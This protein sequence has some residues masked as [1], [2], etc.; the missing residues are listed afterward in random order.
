MLV[1]YSEFAHYSINVL[2]LVYPLAEDE[3]RV[4]PLERRASYAY[5]TDIVEG[6]SRLFGE[7]FDAV[8]TPRPR[9]FRQQFDKAEQLRLIPASLGRDLHDLKSLRNEV[10]HENPR[11]DAGLELYPQ[12]GKLCAVGFALF[13]VFVALYKSR[14]KQSPEAAAV[15]TVDRDYL[16]AALENPQRYQT[17]NPH[18]P[19]WERADIPK[20]MQ[21][22]QSDK[23]IPTIV[24]D[25]PQIVAVLHHSN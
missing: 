4:R 12:L 13:E 17:R 1:F 18:S 9:S 8:G 7:M 3:Y 24:I 16:L 2:G 11:I 14:S 20:A 22:L 15:V 21:K 25:Q 6:A 19:S 10:V 5:L 23:T